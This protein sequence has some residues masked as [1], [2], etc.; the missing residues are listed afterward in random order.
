[1]SRL[2]RGARVTVRCTGRG[3]PLTKRS[4]LARHVG[5]LVTRL[6]GTIFRAGD[7]IFITITAP[8]RVAERAVVTIR[9]GR[10]PLAALL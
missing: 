6:Q 2:P 1:M 8:G 9:N 5:T 10:K 7:R 3:C 4:A